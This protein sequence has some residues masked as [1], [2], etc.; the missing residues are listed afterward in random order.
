ME[1][2]AKN[3]RDYYVVDLAHI[4]KSLWRRIWIIALT[5]ILGAA[6]GFSV[7]SFLIPAKYSS[8]IL[9]YVNNN[10]ISVGNTSFN[11]TASEITAAQSLVNTYGEILESRTTLEKVIDHADVDYS[12]RQL[13]GMIV[14]APANETEIMKVTVTAEDPY[15]AA[16]IANSIAAVLPVRI[17]EIIDG[18]TME[19][20]DDAVPELQKISPSITRYTAVGFLLG[21]VLSILILVVVAMLDDTIHDEE[22]VLQAYDYPILAKVPD[23]L[24]SGSKRYGYY[25][26][27]RRHRN[28]YAMYAEETQNQ[29]GSEE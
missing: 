12:Y 17:S 6:I 28:A 23:L 22:Y 26:S 7:A 29:K 27:R 4:L 1:K 11:I 25:Y 19:V 9:L 13:S 2:R 15:E 14:S 16:K 24:D 8:T 3:S 5:A 10:S 20:V 21:L 18:A